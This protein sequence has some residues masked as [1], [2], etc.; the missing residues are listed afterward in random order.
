[1]K[2]FVPFCVS[3]DGRGDT[4]EVF[5]HQLNSSVSLELQGDQVK[6]VFLHS[7]IRRIEM[8]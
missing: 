6:E 4:K 7:E 3:S 8:C 5:G 2:C 1:M